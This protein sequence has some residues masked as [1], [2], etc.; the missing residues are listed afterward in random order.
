MSAEPTATAEPIEEPKEKTSRLSKL[1]DA[2]ITATCIAV[3]TAV[4]G[5]S[6]WYGW[7]VNAM[8]LET[9]K[10]NLEAAALKAAEARS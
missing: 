8:A 10:L 9:A 7:K 3:P 5:A 1:K 2:T 6:F 4:V